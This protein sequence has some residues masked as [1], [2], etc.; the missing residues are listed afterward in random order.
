MELAIQYSFPCVD[1]L[2]RSVFASMTYVEY[3]QWIKRQFI[4]SL[5]IPAWMLDPMEVDDTRP[6]VSGT[7]D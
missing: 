3:Q 1:E 4:A 2:L 5:N 6:S 7:D